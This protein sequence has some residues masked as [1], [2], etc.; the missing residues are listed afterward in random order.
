MARGLAG[1]RGALKSVEGAIPLARGLAFAAGHSRLL[2]EATFLALTAL[3]AG[4]GSPAAVPGA[5]RA[6][7]GRR[8]GARRRVGARHAPAAR[9][10]L[11]E[12]AVA[13]GMH[14]MLRYGRPA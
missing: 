9:E 8:Q 3:A 14:G 11:A 13:S 5:P 2:G 12:I 4:S 7:V 10:I 1:G 6:R